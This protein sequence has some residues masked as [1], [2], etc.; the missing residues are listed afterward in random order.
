VEVLRE[1]PDRVAIW[2]YLSHEHRHKGT[3]A[4]I[5][6]S[7]SLDAEAPTEL[8]TNQIINVVRGG[9]FHDLEYGSAV[10]LTVQV[11]ANRR[12]TERKL[13]S[14][15][16]GAVETILPRDGLTGRGSYVPGQVGPASALL[17][18]WLDFLEIPEVAVEA[19][20]HAAI[21][22]KL[23]ASAAVGWIVL[24]E[25]DHGSGKVVIADGRHR[26]FAVLDVAQQHGAREVLVLYGEQRR[27]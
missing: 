20:G 25:E 5:A 12:W 1:V 4:S 17:A 7:L 22:K 8:P 18:G 13:T 2:T 9:T 6:H 26:L 24:R 19:A 11:L 15:E 23:V 21:A 14:T 10:F 27:Q 3:L 16:L